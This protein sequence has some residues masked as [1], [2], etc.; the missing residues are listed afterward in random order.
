M[1]RYKKME[2]KLQGGLP[3]WMKEEGT[4]HYIYYKG[5]TNQW[6]IDGNLNANAYNLCVPAD[7]Y[8]KLKAI[9]R[10]GWEHWDGNKFV[11]DDTSLTISGGY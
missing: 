11:T 10:F 4:T 1:G 6:L 2:G 9:P 7:A 8:L 3:V 5:A